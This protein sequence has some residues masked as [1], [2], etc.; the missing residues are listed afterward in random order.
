MKCRTLL[1]ALATG[2]AATLAPA[3]EVTT[4]QTTYHADGSKTV[5]ITGDLVRYEPGQTIVILTG[6]IDLSVSWTLNFAAVLLTLVC[7]L[8]AAPAIGRQSFRSMTCSRTLR[9]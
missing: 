6:G 1:L 8:P 7:C 5:T 4:K 3:Q 9:A 2:A